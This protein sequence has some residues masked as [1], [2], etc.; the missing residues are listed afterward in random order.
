[1]KTLLALLVSA[2]LPASSSEVARCRRSTPLATPET[3]VTDQ[4]LIGRWGDGEN[5]DTTYVVSQAGDTTY[6]LK[7]IPKE[8]GKPHARV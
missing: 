2:R 6:Q 8:T 5:D 1:M 7:C 4:D 3:T